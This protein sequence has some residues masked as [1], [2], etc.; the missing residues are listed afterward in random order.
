M[1]EREETP[2]LNIELPEP[3]PRILRRRA[4]EW[5]VIFLVAILASFAIRTYVVQVF[6]VP[7][8]SM[9]PTLQIGDRLAGHRRLSSRPR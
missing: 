7:S 6:E 1:M 8:G 5:F 9:L 3:R 2:I 4:A